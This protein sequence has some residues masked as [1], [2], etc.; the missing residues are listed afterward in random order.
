M[1]SG[2][3]GAEAEAEADEPGE[4]ASPSEM[5]SEM[6]LQ[7]LLDAGLLSREEYD[8]KRAEIEGR[9][10]RPPGPPRF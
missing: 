4:M 9:V 5:P 2:S 8:T 10:L 3:G 6:D 1:A 7:E